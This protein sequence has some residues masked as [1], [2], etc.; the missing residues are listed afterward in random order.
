MVDM[1][2][3]SRFQPTS[4][5]ILDVPSSTLD[6][7]GNRVG[8]YVQNATTT[9]DFTMTADLVTSW[10]S[11]ISDVEP[12]AV[13]SIDPEL[14]AALL[15]VTGPVALEDGSE[16]TTDNAVERLL[17]EP[18]F[19]F[20]VEDQTT[21]QQESTARL[22]THILGAS[23]DVVTWLQVLS[24]PLEQGRISVWSADSDEQK[25]LSRT[26]AAGPLGRHEQAG[27][28]AFAVYFNDATA[29]KMDPFLKVALSTGAASCRSDGLIETAIGVTLTNDAPLD[30][31]TVFPWWVNGGGLEG[32]EPGTIATNVTVAAP[33]G[34]FPGGVT[35]NGRSVVSSDVDD[36]GFMSSLAQATVAPGESATLE[37]RF[38][39][40]GDETDAH[41][42]LLHTPMIHSPE[43]SG[44]PIA[45]TCD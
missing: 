43:L 7:Y 23:I 20:D 4:D 36:L 41:P 19:R 1:A 22:M 21:Y 8:T 29:G 31:G 10:W 2:D 26:Q 13:I 24:E 39:H 37:F 45:V 18:Y 27:D 14:I 44:T 38:L 33:S 34:S 6:L 5:P 32:V 35:L 9:A 30:A 42:T 40:E 3:S 16:I 11:T 15:A 25:V 12:D 28:D 17:V